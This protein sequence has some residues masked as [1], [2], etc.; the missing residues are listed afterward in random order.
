[1]KTPLC[2]TERDG[3]QIASLGGSPLAE[4]ERWVTRTLKAEVEAL[5]S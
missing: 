1:M 5:A 2:R 4:T 3:V